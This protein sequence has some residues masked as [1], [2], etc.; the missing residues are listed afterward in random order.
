M[1]DSVCDVHE[2]RKTPAE[3][4]SLR[5][6]SK[7]KRNRRQC[8]EGM[9]SKRGRVREARVGASFLGTA[10]EGMDPP[11][12]DGQEVPG[13]ARIVCW[14]GSGATLPVSRADD[15]LRDPGATLRTKHVVVMDQHVLGKKHMVTRTE[16]ALGREQHTA[17]QPTH[18]RGDLTDGS[19]NA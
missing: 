4:P 6:A 1:S 12:V 14:G 19:A 5:K 16:C 8:A 11:L 10:P 18:L 13:Q 7:E 2:A 9:R 17:S 15:K 3:S